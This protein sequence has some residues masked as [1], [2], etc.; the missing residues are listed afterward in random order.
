MKY[1]SY[2]LNYKIKEEA[3][4]VKGKNEDLS[5]SFIEDE[6]ARF[7]GYKDFEEMKDSEEKLIK[8]YSK[9]AKNICNLEEKEFV[10]LKSKYEEKIFQLSKNKNTN[11][12]LFRNITPLSSYILNEN[13]KEKV[14]INL[15]DPVY[16]KLSNKDFEYYMEFLLRSEHL[17]SHDKV[18]HSHIMKFNRAMFKLCKYLKVEDYQDYYIKNKGLDCFLKQLRENPDFHCLELSEF[19]ENSD[20][21][22][23]DIPTEDQIDHHKYITMYLNNKISIR[24]HTNDNDNNKKA[25][26]ISEIRDKKIELLF[27]GKNYTFYGFPEFLYGLKFVLL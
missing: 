22:R 2:D 10:E 13:K 9:K 1:Y 17:L 4:E 12:T 19:L 7:F 6:L 18:F 15:T 26:K 3:E 8:K 14:T 16:L 21:K 20:F 25:I 11:H 27:Y 24:F 23:D 5:L